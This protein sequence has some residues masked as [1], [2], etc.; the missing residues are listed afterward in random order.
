MSKKGAAITFTYVLPVLTVDSHCGGAI[1]D[2]GLRCI[3]VLN[4]SS[5]LP[6]PSLL[7]SHMPP[8]CSVSDFCVHNT[9]FLTIIRIDYVF[10]VKEKKNKVG[11]GCE[12]IMLHF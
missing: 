12:V 2:S 3:S 11:L 9:I 6:S 5:A 7:T 1:T 10:G 4:W 8:P